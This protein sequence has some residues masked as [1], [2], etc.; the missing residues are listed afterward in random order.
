[1]KTVTPSLEVTQEVQSCRLHRLTKI[2]F[3][4]FLSGNR[5]LVFSLVFFYRISKK[6]K[7]CFLDIPSKSFILDVHLQMMPRS[8]VGMS[9][10]CSCSINQA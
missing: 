9:V 2:H 8:G 10:V 6:G 4:P 5:F 7:D 1:M 3:D